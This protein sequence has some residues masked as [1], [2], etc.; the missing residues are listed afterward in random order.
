MFAPVSLRIYKESITQPIQDHIHSHNQIIRIKIRNCTYRLV[1]IGSNE[2][3]SISQVIDLNLLV[4]LLSC[5]LPR[6]IWRTTVLVL[7]L[8]IVLL[9]KKLRI[10]RIAAR[11]RLVLVMILRVLKVSVVG[12]AAVSTI[13]FSLASEG[14]VG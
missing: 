5:S 11:V 7:V 14:A 10:L 6:L 1:R 9:G 13:P 3:V 2:H 4:E 12:R 8:H